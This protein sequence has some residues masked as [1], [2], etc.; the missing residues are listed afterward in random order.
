MPLTTTYY[1]DTEDFA[2]AT[3]VWTS[4]ALTTKALDGYYSF[5]GNYR[6]QFD[7]L[8][9]AINPC[10]TPP[11]P[12]PPGTPSISITS[13]ICNT[14]FGGDGRVLKRFRISVGNPPANYTIVQGTVTNPAGLPFTL[15]TIP[16]NSYLQVTFDQR[17]TFGNEFSIELLLKN[18]SNVTVAT[19]GTQTV[20][21]NF[22]SFLP[23]C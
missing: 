3:A 8:L 10:T 16:G 5:G 1:I 23:A 20:Y 18:E 15:V 19:N 11:P 17:L 22:Q 13:T 14:L 6:R 7:G 9:L 21:G 2:T 12:P 4:P